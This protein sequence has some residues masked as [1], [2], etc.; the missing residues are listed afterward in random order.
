MISVREYL[1][2]IEKGQINTAI[3][4]LFSDEYQ[5]HFIRLAQKSDPFLSEITIIPQIK[6]TNYKMTLMGFGRRALRAGV[7]G[8]APALLTAPTTAPRVLT[9][10]EVILAFD[11][12]DSFLE[13]NIEGDNVTTVIEQGMATL[14]MADMLDLAINGDTADASADAAF[15]T[16]LDGYLAQMAADAGIHQVAAQ[17]TIGGT[18]TKMLQALPEEFKGRREGLRYYTSHEDAETYQDELRERGT[19][20]GD[21]AVTTNLSL[22]R[23]GITVRP[24]SFLP[25][26]TQILTA[27]T[28]LHI[29][30]GRQMKDEPQRQARKRATEH[31]VTA[32]ADVGYADSNAI[33]VAN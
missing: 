2:R 31:T 26:G 17:A 22:V 29:G 9:P 8:V 25:T 3:G 15:L 6:G 16:I 5:M 23:G 14:F 12:T 4:G 18:L 27:A 24:V 7:E 20:L 33:V 1:T 32:S 13:Q 11:I 30:F 21:Q 28:N 10:K 19:V